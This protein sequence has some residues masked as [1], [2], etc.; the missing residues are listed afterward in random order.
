MSNDSSSM[1]RRPRAAYIIALVCLVTALLQLAAGVV[2]FKTLSASESVSPGLSFLPL[3]I[4]V[5]LN[6]GA[7]CAV[8][9]MRVEALACLACL[10][11]RLLARMFGHSIQLETMLDLALL[12]A[13]IYF[14]LRLFKVGTGWRPLLVML[15][16]GAVAGHLTVLIGNLPAYWML[17]GTGSVSFFAALLTLISCVALYVAVLMLHAHPQRAKKLF[18]IAALGSGMSL[19]A[20]DLQYVFSAP[21]WLGVALALIG[22][23]VESR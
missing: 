9:L 3:A 23:F 11:A 18:L 16:L 22:F 1:S 4:S 13:L 15:L 14:T 21:L 7:A 12:V 5:V 2:I 20:W 19:S 17:V 8:Y 6:L 10:L